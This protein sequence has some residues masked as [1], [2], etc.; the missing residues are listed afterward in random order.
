MQPTCRFSRSAQ[1]GFCALVH[2]TMHRDDSSA[3]LARKLGIL[4]R[5]MNLREIGIERFAW[6]M[7]LPIGR[8]ALKG[9]LSSIPSAV[10][11]A[12]QFNE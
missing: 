6:P 9:R 11:S 3:A 2:P 5:M 4:I 12:Q 10:L 7:Y 8:S 1:I